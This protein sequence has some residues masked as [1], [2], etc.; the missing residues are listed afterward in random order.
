MQAQ[1]IAN[2]V[3]F[4]LWNQVNGSRMHWIICGLDA[5]T[6]KNRWQA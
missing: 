6:A 5:V 2:H 1:P 4:T 3:P